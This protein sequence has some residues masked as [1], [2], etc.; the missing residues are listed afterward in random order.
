MDRDSANAQS[1]LGRFDL[2]QV[3][4]TQDDE[5]ITG[6]VSPAEKVSSALYTMVDEFVVFSFVVCVCF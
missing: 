2:G 4:V 1:P 3:M 6:V 5:P